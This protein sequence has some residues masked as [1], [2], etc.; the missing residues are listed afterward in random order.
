MQK[1]KALYYVSNGVGQTE[2]AKQPIPAPEDGFLTV[3]TENKGKQESRKKDGNESQPRD[4]RTALKIAQQ[5]EKERGKRAFSTF[6]ITTLENV[7]F[8]MRIIS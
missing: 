8:R 6:V 1:I 5:R 3:E 7:R 4:L 2:G